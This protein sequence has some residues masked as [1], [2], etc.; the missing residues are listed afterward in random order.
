MCQ[1]QSAS[2]REGIYFS[3][4]VFGLIHYFG[5]FFWKSS[6]RGKGGLGIYKMRTDEIFPALNDRGRVKSVLAE[7]RDAGMPFYAPS[8]LY[9]TSWRALTMPWAS[10][11]H[12]SALSIGMALPRWA[13]TS[14]MKALILLMAGMMF[15]LLSCLAAF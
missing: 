13:S 5:W 12:L 6:P 9:R 11:A 14:L 8:V 1:K 2:N 10:L 3:I 7:S 15:P 4:H